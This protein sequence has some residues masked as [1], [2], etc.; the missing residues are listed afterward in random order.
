MLKHCVLC[1]DYTEEWK[2]TLDYLPVFKSLLQLEKL[3]LVHVLESS[4]KQRAHDDPATL[5]IHLDGLAAELAGQLDIETDAVVLKG[6]V[7]SEIINHAGKINADGI[8]ALNYSH[9]A[10]REVLMGNVVVNL[11]RMTFLPL[12]VIARDGKVPAHDA[13]VL[14]G[15]DGSAANSNALACFEKFLEEGARGI[16]IWVDDDAHDDEEE[17]HRIL[18]VLRGKHSNVRTRQMKGSS[19]LRLIEAADE[20]EAALLLVGRRGTTPLQPL[21]IGSTTEAL[22]RESRQ[23]V[24]LIPQ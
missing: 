4:R 13:P 12:L 9:S 3:T 10:S 23:P 15:T 17:A 18:A 21:L 24:L 20:E 11:A 8:I 7:A 22:I 6:L 14:L 16:A 2:C 19:V 5:K 1:V